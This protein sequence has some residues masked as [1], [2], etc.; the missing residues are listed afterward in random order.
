ML[1]AREV[2]VESRRVAYPQL[3]DVLLVRLEGGE[4]LDIV[5]WERDLAASGQ[6]SIDGF[7][8]FETRDDYFAGVDQLL[9]EEFGLLVAHSADAYH[10]PTRPSTQPRSKEFT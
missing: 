10:R 2:S 3:R 6:G 1:A 8:P 9:G 4:W 7:P 5:V